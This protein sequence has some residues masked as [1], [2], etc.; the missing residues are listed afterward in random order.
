MKRIAVLLMSLALL[1]I[2]VA[3]AAQYDY[4]DDESMIGG[5]QSEG[6]E[7]TVGGDGNLGGAIQVGGSQGGDIQIGDGDEDAGPGSVAIVDFA[8][9][10]SALFVSAGDTVE[11]ANV[12][13]A[14]HTVDSDT[15]IFSSGTIDPGGGYSTTFEADG[16]FTY[17]CDIHPQ[18]RGTV[19]VS[20]A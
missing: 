11:W 15:G 19:I 4:P 3:V 17:H 13:A 14:P 7:I 12:G 6:G 1:V 10:P 20:G 8:F 18:M 16:V 9:D 5:G 2:P